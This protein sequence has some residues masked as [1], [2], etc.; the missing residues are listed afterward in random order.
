MRAEGEMEIEVDIQG[1]TVKIVASGVVVR[2]LGAAWGARGPPRAPRDL[3]STPARQSRAFSCLDPL[4]TLAL[5]Q[6]C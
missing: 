3:G 1:S 5:T 6:W 4:A 2:A